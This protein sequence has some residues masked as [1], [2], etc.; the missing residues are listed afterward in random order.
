MRV[1]VVDVG[2]NST[3]LLITEGTRELHRA[4]VVT[5]LGDRV[6][7]SGRLD[8]EAQRR[9]LGLLAAYAQEIARHGCVR[10]VALMTSAVRDAANGRA[11]AAR[12]RELGLDGRIISGDEEARLTFAGATANRSPDGLAVIDIGGGSTE[13]VTRHFHVSTQVGVVR[14]GERHADLGALAAEVR[15]I[16]GGLALPEVQA[17]VGVAGT[18]TSAAAIDLGGYDRDRVEGHRLTIARLEEIRDQLVRL[19]PEQ[20]RAV[21]G[22]QPDRA[23]VMLPGLTILLEALRVLGLDRIEVSEHDLM[24]GAAAELGG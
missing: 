6:D 9:V 8:D 24:W 20:R 4:S 5:R 19:T 11:F 17:A 1:G 2:T 16:F 12:V 18:P 7:A 13:I 10:N 23:H 22:L 15:A 14:Q 3:R 21:P